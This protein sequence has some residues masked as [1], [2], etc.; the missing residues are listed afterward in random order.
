MN[1]VIDPW[2]PVVTIGGKPHFANLMQVFTEGEKYADL[3]VRPHERVALM[4]LLICI[5]QSALDGPVGKDDWK[6]T[7]KKLPES[8]RKYLDK[9]NKEE[10][11]ELFHKEKPFLQIAVLKPTV[12]DSKDEKEDKKLKIKQKTEK[13]E[14]FTSLSKLDISLATGANSTLLDHQASATEKRVLDDQQI[15]LGLITYLN[16]SASGR[17][18]VALW[19]S[20]ESPGKGASFPAPGIDK[21]MVHC[22]LRGK[23]LLHSICQ[24]ILTKPVI[25]RHFGKKDAWGKPI[26]ESFPKGF[27]DEKAIQNATDTYLGRLVPLSRAIKIRKQENDLLLANG[28]RYP[29]SEDG[30]YETSATLK[31]RDNKRVVLKVNSNAI[32]RE[33]HAITV[34]K[35]DNNSLASGPRALE[36][37]TDENFDVWCGGIEWTTKGGYINSMES[38]YNVSSKMLRDEC[39]AIYQ[40]EVAHAEHISSNLG[41]AMEEY[42]KNIDGYWN[43]RS[44]P[45]KNKNA[46]KEKDLLH[47]KAT[48]S[49]WTA[50]EKQRH[51]LMAYVDLFDVDEKYQAAQKVWRGAIHKAARE[52]YITA[53]GKETPREIRAFALGWKKLFME[54]KPETE[55]EDQNSDGGEE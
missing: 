34:R 9:W 38:V 39:R 53:C 28:L 51:L 17:I 49:Y 11:F 10:V 33:L 16:F 32:W 3:S 5:A 44:D 46:F 52:A 14:T 21:L 4:R 45:K 54:K 24:N 12:K 2:I 47:S 29:L 15:A 41:W 40:N 22:F 18:G 8:A 13:V 36:N 55:N 48:R 1:L 35:S 23:N 37:L 27:D 50:I 25:E 19:N 26:W 31:V 7:P 20:V 43:T 30:M 42:R 6:A